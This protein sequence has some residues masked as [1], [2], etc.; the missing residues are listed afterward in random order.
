[1]GVLVCPAR[2][3]EGTTGGGGGESTRPLASPACLLFLKASGR[4]K[5]ANASAQ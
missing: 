2:T 3:Q 5:Q 1:V 4:E